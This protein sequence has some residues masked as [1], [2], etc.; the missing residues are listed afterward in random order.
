MS[1]KLTG[2]AESTGYCVNLLLKDPMATEDDHLALHQIVE[3]L[4]SSP[5]NR[6]EETIQTGKIW[7]CRVI[8]ASKT[9]FGASGLTIGNPLKDAACR[10]VFIFNICSDNEDS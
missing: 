4:S 7:Q 6:A 9:A 8:S 10:V 1:A 5:T 2:L 3:L